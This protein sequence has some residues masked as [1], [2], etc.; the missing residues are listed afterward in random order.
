MTSHS[1][2]TRT[3]MNRKTYEPRLFRRVE[4][5]QTVILSVRTIRFPYL[6]LPHV[7]HFSFPGRR[8]RHHVHI[9]LSLSSFRAFSPSGVENPRKR[10]S[11]VWIFRYL[12]FFSC[13]T[14]FSIYNQ[15]TTALLTGMYGRWELSRN[16][17]CIRKYHSLYYLSLHLDSSSSRYQYLR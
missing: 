13:G 12:F 2:H 15:L 3:R 1:M 8:L 6:F 5:P 11:L 10:K 14:L 16:L 9:L 17:L 7:L 4:H